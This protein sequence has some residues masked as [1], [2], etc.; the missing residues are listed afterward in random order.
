MFVNSPKVNTEVT[1]IAGDIVDELKLGRP[2]D[3]V[4]MLNVTYTLQPYI[5]S[6]TGENGT[7]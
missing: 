6:N 7:S 4:D 3:G 5:Y 1:D 2:A